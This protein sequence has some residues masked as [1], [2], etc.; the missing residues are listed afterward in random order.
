M[1]GFTVYLNGEHFDE[2]FF[3]KSMTCEDVKKSLVEHDGLPD[4]IV[5][6]AMRV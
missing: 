5:V 6:K 3:S 2:V 4:T 1:N